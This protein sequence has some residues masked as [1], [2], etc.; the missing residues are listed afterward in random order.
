MHAALRTELLKLRQDD[1]E[2]RARL[3]ATGSLFQ[4]YDPGMETVHRRNAARL[5]EIIETHGWPGT[6]LVGADGAEAAW[7]IAQH[8]IGEPAF[9]RRCLELLLAG[10]ASDDV[11]AW[12]PAYL[13]D[14]IRMF[15]GRK[16]RYGTQL[17]TGPGGEPVPYP[18]EEPEQV[19]ERRRAVG[20]P[21][22]ADHLARADRMPA[23]SPAEREE[24]ERGY[25]AW[26]K[27]TG[28][29]D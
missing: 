14:R 6:G 25:R 17:D 20:L 2:T 15:E 26:L 13:E 9:Q 7:L 5:A 12:Q 21:P 22:L 28:W 3:A 4:G 23:M 29:R 18:I 11:P 24:W 16:Q 10:V 27:R 1:L 19:D 8:A